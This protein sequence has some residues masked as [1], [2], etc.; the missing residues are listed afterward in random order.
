VRSG[1]KYDVATDSSNIEPAEGY[2]EN[3]V[4][5]GWTNAVFL[6]LMSGLTR[7]QI[8]LVLAPPGSVAQR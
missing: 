2:R 1:E 4:G 5:F 6:E 7:E 8:K 3:V